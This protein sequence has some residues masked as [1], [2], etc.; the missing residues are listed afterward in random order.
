MPTVAEA[1]ARFS[2]ASRAVAGT[3]LATYL[4]QLFIP[5]FAD[6]F[7]LVSGRAITRPWTLVTSGLVQ[8]SFFGVSTL[9]IANCT[10]LINQITQK[11][12]FYSF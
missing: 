3:L 4:L 8:Q 6:F 9:F 2:P 1:L 7:G 10:F 5:G 12:S 11:P